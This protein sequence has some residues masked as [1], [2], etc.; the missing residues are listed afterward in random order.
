MTSESAA[1]RPTIHDLQA[2]AAGAR[3]KLRRRRPG[4]SRAARLHLID[5]LSRWGGAGLALIAGVA[6][7]IAVSAGREA[8]L[9]A[10]AWALMMLA[11]LHV[12]RLL[13]NRF[14][15]GEDIAA[16]PF[17]WRAEYTA[18]LVALGAAFGSGSLIVV[19][20]GAAQAFGLETLA[21]IL[22]G[23]LGA[24][25]LHAAHGRSAAALFLP[26]GLFSILG[27][28]RIGGA[29]LALYG[30]AAMLVAGAL[31]LF[32]LRR[33]WRRRAMRRFPRTGFIRREAAR[34]TA[35]DETGE[36]AAAA[37]V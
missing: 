32:F 7:F 17:R 3:R 9:R 29:P 13:R 26:A 34:G 30:A 27:A 11:A 20:P 14:R 12:C 19:A 4:P 28:W 16:R 35:E 2:M 24:A 21:L 10:S 25:A 33:A 18:A 23:A 36:D 5:A 37:A 15:A 8:P 1:A 31:L 22:V 6:I